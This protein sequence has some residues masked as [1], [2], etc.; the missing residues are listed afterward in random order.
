MSIHW[1]S[2]VWMWPLLLVLAVG[3][4]LLTRWVYRQ[5]WPKPSVGLGRVLA[6]L[7]GSVLV[8]LIAAIAGPIISSLKEVEEPAA[9]VVV[10]EDSGS[11]AI[12]D[13]GIVGEAGSGAPNRWNRALMLAAQVDSSLAAIGQD[14][15]TTILRGNGLSPAL[16]IVPGDSEYASPV[17]LGTD[18]AR[19]RN[20]A[21][22]HLAGRPL[23]AV[24]LVS[25]GRETVGRD[26]GSATNR[27][28]RFRNP[29][30]VHG[31][32]Q[33]PL[34]AVG[35]G[36]SQGPADRMVKDLRYPGTAFQ[37]DEVVVELAVVHRFTG[38]ISLPPV[39]ARLIGPGGQ[40]A[41][42]TVPADAEVVNLELVFEP[43]IVGP[44]AYRLEVSSLVN[45]RFLEN[46]EVSL[47]IDIRQERSSLLLLCERPGWDV[48]FL[49]QAA[50]REQRLS[51]SVVYNSVGGLVF[52]DSL[53][54]WSEP[55]S[56]AG[57]SA[58]DGLILMGWTGALAD[59]D[60]APLRGAVQAGL[61][62]LVFPGEG[63]GGSPESLAGSFAVPDPDLL[64][65]LPVSVGSR[66]WRDGANSIFTPGNSG[67]HS[68]LE[69]MANGA[70]M[71][72][73]STPEGWSDLPPLRGI[74]DV[75][76]RP[77]TQV[78]LAAGS[79]SQ[80][81]K[82]SVEIPLL[83][84]TRAESG[85]VG[86]FGGRDLWE[87]AFWEPERMGPGT[88]ADPEQIARKLVRN[89][90]VWTAEGEQEKELVLS[91]R[92]TSYQ[93]G[94]TIRL[95]SLWKDMRGQPVSGRKLSLVLGAPNA[96]PDS[97]DALAGRGYQTGQGER[98]F[99]LR[100]LV[101]Y[102]GAAEVELPPLPPG[103][104]TVQLIGQAD[105]PVVGL[106]ENLVVTR[107]SIESTQVRQDSR[108]LR[109][110]AAGPGDH[111]VD[112]HESGALDR[113]L[114]LLDDLDWSAGVKENRARTDLLSGWPFLALAAFLLGIEWFL[115]RRNGML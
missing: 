47:A 32:L 19:L 26:L 31:G 90:L 65:M 79:R 77:G 15:Q 40:V 115:R 39:T 99:P 100:E 81:G 51:L 55:T 33:V 27:M 41:E 97:L 25:D 53:K 87:L 20:Q 98:T 113:I 50:A 42:A 70:G 93:E 43:T 56:A 72:I 16:E 107:H 4:V 112:G 14:V 13:C 82:S 71:R 45:E 57:W 49:A 110:L 104:Y 62:L 34:V 109:Q 28:G 30:A 9:L 21:I 52:A 96:G 89:L 29:P 10:L 6:L 11:M 36:D 68:V 114:D 91:G 35:V 78:L 18:L 95:T 69:G 58:W 92:R 105:P 111:Y 94:E 103:A 48:R 54:P 75:E 86:W 102:P 67:S 2:P 74:F 44:Q 108:R 64:A 80:M 12:S 73:S 37:G 59:L 88:Q 3:A 7:R 76:S 23:R 83:A 106:K 38:E 24:V 84:V 60:W 46:N 61:G 5:T 8:L 85:R 17:A 22:E 63:V 1:T 66:E 101:G